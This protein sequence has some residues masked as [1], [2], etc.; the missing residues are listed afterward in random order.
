MSWLNKYSE[1]VAKAQKGKTIG[2][3]SPKQVGDVEK[4]R[5]FINNWNKNRIVKNKKINSNIEIPFSEDIYIDGLNN[6]T[7]DN[8]KFKQ[9]GEFD[10]LTN[11]IILDENYT[12]RQ[13]IP[14]HEFNHRFQK[15]LKNK[16]LKIYN[17]YI[18]TPI[19]NMSK[20][21]SQKDPYFSDPEEIHS[22]LI[23]MRYN[24][25]FQPDQT[26]NTQDLKNLED[27]NLK[28]FSEKELIELLNTTAINDNSELISMQKGGSIK[29][30]IYVNDK[31]DP[32][33]RAYQDS[34]NLH[35]A[36]KMQD[37][38]MGVGSEINKRKFNKNQFTLKQL[39]EDR[40]IDPKYGVGRDYQ[41]E[42][43]FR[44]EAKTDT[45]FVRPEDIKLLDY[46]KKLG[47][48]N[49]NIMYHQSLDIVSDKI[50]PI[51]E[52]YDGTANSPIYK[53][54]QQPVIVKDTA[55]KE[56]TKTKSGY[57]LQNDGSKYYD[58][59]IPVG[60]Y[61]DPSKH[62]GDGEYKL[63]DEILPRKKLENI[64]RLTPQ[65]IIVSNNSLEF[66][67]NLEI[68]QPT[69]IPKYY[70][71]TDK[72]NQKFG[73]S[74]TSYKW[75]PQDENP[76]QELSQEKYEDGTL[77]N[78]RTMIPRFEDGGIIEDDMG[79]WSYPGEVTRI[80][81][82]NIT[83]KNVKQR[84]LGISDTGDMQLMYPEQEYKFKGKNVTEFP[85][86]QTGKI[87]SKN[88]LDNY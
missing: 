33:Y 28:Q 55:S 38:L 64:L 78:E 23:R 2:N 24:N 10:S 87:I 57:V 67:P 66:I 3:L 9:L 26:I 6:S 49:N 60:K 41:N 59:S 32:K 50:R 1:V 77:Y 20:S 58:K 81:S 45:K 54:P 70:D 47:F 71:I 74:E 85:I 14:A 62:T 39:K 68:K 43:E 65:P 29:K 18:D 48:N 61:V 86:A 19:Q 22:E 52:Y 16:N 15:D 79:Q 84:L 75:Y 42:K 35:L 12:D 4:Q 34:L 30:P 37:K 88:W 7:S 82:P 25:S 53:K 56:N 31:N 17:E 76:L 73:G 8:K 63:L 69:R 80:N 27:Y 40:V 11:R 5:E 13:G 51:G 36:Y 72:V 83:M 21:N 44:K 46:Y